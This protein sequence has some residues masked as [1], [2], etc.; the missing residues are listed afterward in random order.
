MIPA[1]GSRSQDLNAVTVHS[2]DNDDAGAEAHSDSD[3]EEL[4]E[5]RERRAVA[6]SRW[7]R[8]YAQVLELARLGFAGDFG[9]GAY[10]EIDLRGGKTL[11]PQVERKLRREYRGRVEVQVVDYCL[12]AARPRLV[13]WSNYSYGAMGMRA[14]RE[15]LDMPRP[16]L[17]LLEP[18]IRWVK[19]EGFAWDL[20]KALAGR[21]N[22][23]PLLV[24]DLLGVENTEV[25]ENFGAGGGGG[26]GGGGAND[27]GPAPGGAGG[28]DGTWVSGTSMPHGRAAARSG[29]Q[30]RRSRNGPAQQLA[31]GGRSSGLLGSGSWDKPP[32]GAYN[33]GS[34]SGAGGGGGGGGGYGG[35]GGGAAASSS[36]WW[37]PWGRAD[38]EEEPLPEDPHRR[39]KTEYYGSDGILYISMSMIGLRTRLL[40]R[41][42]A[43][44]QQAAAAAAAAD[45]EPASATAT[46]GGVDAA[47]STG[48]GIGTGHGAH[49]KAAEAAAGKKGV[50]VNN[51][52][53]RALEATIA[54]AM[55]P[56]GGG[57]G[58]G[59][60]G[61]GV[62]AP[63][64]SAPDPPAAS[65]A[66]VAAAAAA[67]SALVSV[68]VGSDQ[69]TAAG[70]SVV[71][72]SATSG[73]SAAAAQVA[74][75]AAAD[76]A[77]VNVA[78]T[79][80]GTRGPAAVATATGG[81]GSAVLVDTG[82]GTGTAAVH[83]H[84]SPGGA[85]SIGVGADAAAVGGS[86]YAEPAHHHHDHGHRHRHHRGGERRS[87]EM[88][89]A[90]GSGT[91]G[92][93]S[94]VA[95]VGVETEGPHSL[96]AW[97][98]WLRGLCCCG[99]AP[100]R[101]RQ[102]PRWWERL[103]GARSRRSRGDEYRYE[104]RWV[105]EPLVLLLVQDKA[106]HGPNGHAPLSMAGGPAS[107]V[108]GGAQGGA[109]GGVG[110]SVHG[111]NSGVHGGGAGGARGVTLI[112]MFHYSGRSVTYR[113]WRQ[114]T[115]GATGSTAIAA[116]AA[117]AMAAA[118]TAAS[119][120]HPRGPS[121]PGGPGPYPAVAAAARAPTTGPG[122]GVAAAAA[123]AVTATA[124]AGGA[125]EG[126]A[127]PPH[128]PG[129][130]AA[131]GSGG[132][133]G[134]APT[135][136]LQAPLLQRV[137]TNAT[138]AGVS[139]SHSLISEVRRSDAGYLLYL[140]MRGAVDQAYDV[141]RDFSAQL[142]DFERRVRSGNL[143]ATAT[144]QLHVMSTDL[145]LLDRRFKATTTVLRLLITKDPNNA[146]SGTVTDTPLQLSANTQAKLK[147]LVEQVRGINDEID[148]LGTQAAQ[149]TDL[150]FNLI[151]HRSNNSM[152]VLSIISTVFLPVTFLA[153]VYGTN[154]VWVPELH[155][156]LGY[157]YFWLLITGV[158]IVVFAI[159]NKYVH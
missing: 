108:L 71:G 153:G 61:E 10:I 57:F 95:D 85:V 65:G 117:A 101:G 21:Y 114:I 136:G 75:S 109:A 31:A 154:F 16:V 151:A 25:L 103:L 3:D 30:R 79:A 158:G 91:S 62:E 111:G 118:A 112:S 37:W 14:L 19:V 32:P 83:R 129:M 157:M 76:A 28:W 97:L 63:S 29:S 36:G 26:G 152:R 115:S 4:R 39:I 148:S 1:V 51:P 8:A 7:R 12:T 128:P 133:G 155:W 141:V 11:P 89:W 50:S 46:S 137:S 134:G 96:E 120:S 123:A 146:D 20:V 159:A 82:T 147:A 60:L 41:S 135:P 143:S 47:T 17:S 110:G 6:R 54:A 92:A 59:P 106:A 150:V 13:R 73:P 131:V 15:F 107:G 90:G 94:S 38:K 138:A 66:V 77:A 113:I 2:H 5:E 55:R 23:P 74:A 98:R 84:H 100:G 70:Q 24:S 69:S 52:I 116:A 87:G 104:K 67:S 145:Q 126:S 68:A 64:A 78:A 35:G 86:G 139:S 33:G 43:E 125:G 27:P 80:V 124:G 48:P 142:S 44:Q 140:I 93:G 58:G 42:A 119:F 81:A 122:A 45:L 130:V 121:G 22:L 144:E 156:Q 127:M 34:A 149:L 105:E 99:R 102:R 56:G 40:L 132:R 49:G 88:G 9:S 18:Q 53:A 72:R